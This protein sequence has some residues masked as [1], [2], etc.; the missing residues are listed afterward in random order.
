ML[1]YAHEEDDNRDGGEEGGGEQILPLNHIER[2]ELRDADRYRAVC[3]GGDEHRG[4]SILIPRID[5]HEDKRGDYAG[6]GH[7][8]EHIDERA[9]R[10]A[11]VYLRGLLHFWRD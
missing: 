10:C 3:G 1:F 6:R 11:A 2:R 9:E 5:E 4:D 7:G 8:D